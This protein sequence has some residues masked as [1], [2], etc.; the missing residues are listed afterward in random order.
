MGAKNIEME[1]TFNFFGGQFFGR[2]LSIFSEGRFVIFWRA[3]FVGANNI[4]LEGTFCFFGGHNIIV[5]TVQMDG[6]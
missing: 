2:A 4:E 1:G 3:S 6:Y 5:S